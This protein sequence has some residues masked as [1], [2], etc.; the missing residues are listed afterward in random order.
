MVREMRH[1]VK[2]NMRHFVSPPA[3]AAAAAAWCPVDGR[4]TQANPIL[5]SVRSSPFVRR[6]NSIHRPL[7]HDDAAGGSSSSSS[8]SRD[9]Q[10][11]L[12]GRL[13]KRRRTS[14]GTS[15]RNVCPALVVVS[16]FRGRGPKN[17]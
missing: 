8:S 9:E 17:S 14:H 5:P 3:A 11:D 4:M 12:Q 15:T 7:Q 2:Q 1:G 6:A 16:G 13:S 10:Y